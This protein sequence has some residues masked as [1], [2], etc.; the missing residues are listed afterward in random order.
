ML[1]FR[2]LLHRDDPNPDVSWDVTPC[3]LD[4]VWATFCRKQLP[5]A[6]R[7]SR[8]FRMLVSEDEGNTLLRNVS[9]YRSKQKLREVVESSPKLLPKYQI[10]ILPEISIMLL[11][12]WR[13]PY[14]GPS[15]QSG[16]YIYPLFYHPQALYFVYTG[17]FFRMILATNS[18]Y[19]L[20]QH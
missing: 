1:K 14:F 11:Q 12:S 7:P 15:W 16:N 9:N 20:H 18:D 13:M 17:C 19:S 6:S 5:R 2:P 3:L 10:K 4:N 8:I